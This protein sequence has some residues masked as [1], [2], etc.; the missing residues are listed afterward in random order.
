M[1]L[2]T[3]TLHLLGAPTAE[4]QA[5]LL[6]DDLLRTQNAPWLGV[7]PR[8]A[9]EVKRLEKLARK[10]TKEDDSRAAI[11]F[12]W[13]DDDVFHC[14]FYREGRRRASC[15]S[16]ESWAKLGKQLNLL[17]GEDAPAKAFRY[18][19]RCVDL[20]EQLA[21]M[22]ETVGTALLDDPED[23]PR[24]V[25]RSDQTLHAIKA[26]EAALRRRPNR[27]R[28]TEVP[29]DAWPEYMRAKHRLYEH[30][31]PQ[32]QSNAAAEIRFSAGVPS[33]T[34]PYHPYLIGVRN[35][36]MNDSG[37]W[38]CYDARKDQMTMFSSDDAFPR[39]L[40]QT[41]QGNFVCMF[42]G[43]NKVSC[44]RPNGTEAWRFAPNAGENHTI[45]V[46]GV[47]SDGS[48]LLADSAPWWEESRAWMVDGVTGAV[49][50][51]AQLPCSQEFRL[52]CAVN[53]VGAV[54][55][56]LTQSALIVLDE[57]LCE[58]ARWSAS[59]LFQGFREEQITGDRVWTQGT[60]NRPVKIIDLQTGEETR[61]KLEI[62]AYVLSVLSDG[63]ILASDQKRKTVSMFDACGTLSARFTLQGLVRTVVEE[64]GRVLLV[65]LRNLE[66]YFVTCEETLDAF[67]AHVWRLDEI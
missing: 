51:Q 2:T 23:E 13:F 31:R 61:I 58:K 7:T 25:P 35:F 64:K 5:Q 33:Y 3:V 55:Y 16:A 48:I 22:E 56:D 37:Q 62:P 46:V 18:A 8:S 63:R 21:L 43:S 32:W 42:S 40:W 1:G 45:Y 57:T 10:L 34:A 12:F 66:E 53:G 28:L 39:L 47:F 15:I 50:A 20:E 49:T 14:D 30:L 9:L 24:V 36:R 52:C 44:V 11:V 38:L 6:P 29:Q 41:K 4:L 65:E 60:P 26:R 59:A 19:G 67:S 17:Y 54:G 27:Y